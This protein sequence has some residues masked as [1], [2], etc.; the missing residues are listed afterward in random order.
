MNYETVSCRH[1]TAS[2]FVT[3]VLGEVFANFQ[4]FAVNYQ[5]LI[6]W[7]D[8]TNFFM[9]EPLNVKKNVHALHFAL[10]LSRL[11]QSS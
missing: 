5:E 9:D 10:H 1:A 2:T 11:F 3:K 6:V 4:A 8:R 7:P